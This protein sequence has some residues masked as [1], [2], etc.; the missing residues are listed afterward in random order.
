MVFRATDVSKIT[1]KFKEGGTKTFTDVKFIE[2]PDSD[3]TM[4]SVGYFERHPDRVDEKLFMFWPRDAKL[5]D[6]TRKGEEEIEIGR[7][8]C[9]ERV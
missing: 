6:I 4:G 7:A 2:I 1:I 8:S 5:I 9:R 3:T